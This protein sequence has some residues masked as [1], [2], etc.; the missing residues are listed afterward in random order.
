[1]N[2]DRSYATISNQIMTKLFG[3]MLKIFNSNILITNRSK[4]V[5]FFT[6][7]ICGFDNQ[8]CKEL[9]DT[10]DCLYAK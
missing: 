5:Q 8:M 1:M 6:I 7:Y 3:I 10:K 9:S 2:H 4:C